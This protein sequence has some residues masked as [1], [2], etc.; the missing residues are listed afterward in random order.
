M[1]RIRRI[2]KNSIVAF[3]EHCTRDHIGAY[4]ATG[5]YFIILSFIP[6]TLLLMTSVRLTPVNREMV[7]E[8]ILGL[9]PKAFHSFL[10]GIIHEVYSRSV[11]I[12]PLTAI[13]ALWSSGKGFHAITSGFNVIYEI[14]DSEKNYFLLRLRSIAYT[15]LFIFTIIATLVFLVFGNK[16]QDLLWEYAPFL[17][18]ASRWFL[19]LRMVITFLLLSIFFTFMYTLIPTN[20]LHLLR[21]IPGAILAAASWLLFSYGFSFYVDS[22]K[23]ISVMYGS[24]TIVV[25]VML[26]M[27]FCMYLLLLGAQVNAVIEKKWFAPR[28]RMK[29]AK[30]EEKR[31]ENPS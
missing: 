15:L 9:T 18:K 23:G 25:L 11:A 10:D 3:V 12:L 2:V 29:E 19:N 27:Y 14:K 31:R 20:K 5:A 30:K 13:I 1:K 22:S 4:A 21:Q 6:F 24:L 28:A 16:I 26:W 8:A 7:S 17:A